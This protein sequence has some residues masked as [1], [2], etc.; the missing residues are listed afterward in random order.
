MGDL[1]TQPV[2]D[3]ASSSRIILD[4]RGLCFVID[5]ETLMSLPESI[6]LCLFPNGLMLP[7]PNDESTEGGEEGQV[8]YVDV[9]TVSLTI[10]SDAHCLQFVLTFFRHAQEYFYGTDTTPGIYQGAGLSPN[11]FD[12]ADPMMN[13]LG[14][15]FHLPLF[16]KQ[17]VIVLREEL[18]YFTIPPSSMKTSVLASANPHVPPPVTPEY[19]QLKDACGESLLMRRQIFTALQRNVNKENN[20][21]EQ[22]LID[23]LCMSGFEPD[24]HW[25][26][27]AREP[28]RCGITS[29]ALVLLKT[30]VT[31]PSELPGGRPSNAPPPR[32]PIGVQRKGIDMEQGMP[33][34]T[35]SES[36]MGEWVDDGQGGALRVNQQQLSTTQKLLLFWRKPARKCW[37][38]GMDM[39]VPCAQRRTDVP[40]VTPAAL[41]AM[42]PQ[43]R[44]WLEQR[45]G[46]LVRVWVRRVWT[47]EV[48]LATAQDLCKPDTLS[49]SPAGTRPSRRPP[50]HET[51]TRPT[52][53]VPIRQSSAPVATTME[54][55][56]SLPV[57][58][59]RE[60]E[61][62]WQSVAQRANRAGSPASLP[63]RRSVISPPALNL[64]E[65]TACTYSIQ[66]SSSQAS[67]DAALLCNSMDCWWSYGWPSCGNGTA[68]VSP[69]RTTHSPLTPPS[70]GDETESLPDSA[71]SHSRKH[72]SWVPT[73][74]ENEAMALR[75]CKTPP[76]LEHGRYTNVVKPDVGNWVS[77]Q[78]DAQTL[79]P[80]PDTSLSESM[81][82]HAWTLAAATQKRFFPPITSEASCVFTPA[83]AAKSMGKP[84]PMSFYI[85]PDHVQ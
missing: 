20:L 10:Q 33:P 5:R 36:E 85:H 61:S 11:Y 59:Q 51:A 76:P 42:S 37:W 29:T 27:R 49:A 44:A 45:Q 8:I 26:Y 34:L 1:G 78:V 19:T 24:D 16:H 32:R 57:A 68:V 6:L 84:E 25:G 13:G 3:Y 4:L 67:K 30:G 53:P 7:D 73:S 14:Q 31:H 9:R 17:A 75:S 79:P 15:P 71:Q 38:D 55:S 64:S 43:E 41:A 18:E 47:L 77:S 39:V 62:Q 72:M 23:M 81:S 21:A 58:T 40:N 50:A 35:P 65:D 22:H 82:K 48:S 70:L 66:V 28:A 56:Y 46:M 74:L 2:D 12:M 60:F 54:R 80:L 69:V 63:V 52:P 83:M